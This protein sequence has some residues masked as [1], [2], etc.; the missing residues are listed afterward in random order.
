LLVRFEVLT[1]V[2]LAILVSGTWRFIAG[3]MGP[4]TFKAVPINHQWPPT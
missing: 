4:D 2:L 1:A 3:C